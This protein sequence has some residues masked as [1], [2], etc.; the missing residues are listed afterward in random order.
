MASD[1][2]GRPGKDEFAPYYAGYVEEAKV[3]DILA[4]L[5]DQCSEV[6][7]LFAG[8]PVTMG[9]HRYAP[10]KWTIKEVLGHVIDSERVFAYRAL[11]FARG[12]RTPQPGFE[13]DDYVRV[14]AFGR[15]PMENLLAEFEHLRLS[16]LALFHSFGAD[17]W[18]AVGV[19]NEVK[20]S[21]RA[22]AYIIYGHAA[23]H[24]TVIQERYL[25]D[26]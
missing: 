4:A 17:K 10:G 24:L 7:E 25:G 2:V 13:Q 21:V 20:F 3:P 26:G 12:E 23:H 19:A 16:N 6:V 22:L 5:E 18:R 8:L 9:D 14:A 1:A 11:S 15:R